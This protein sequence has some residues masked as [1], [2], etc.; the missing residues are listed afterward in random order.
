MQLLQA[1]RNAAGRISAGF[2]DSKLFQ[3][4]G[5]KGEFRERVIQEFLRPFLP[6]CYGL[7]SG[8]VFSETGAS[9]KQID[10]VIYDAAFS[11]VLFRDSQNSLFP[12]E[13]VYGNIEVKSSLTV[14]ELEGAIENI[15]SLKRLQRDDSDMLDLLPF[16]RL[17]VGSGLRY[18]RTKRNPYLGMVVAYSGAAPAAI[19]AALNGQV[20]KRNEVSGLLPDCIFVLDKGYAIVRVADNP[21]AA[22][23][24]ISEKA[25]VCLYKAFDCQGDILPF[26][27]LTLN[28]ALNKII[29]RAPDLDRYW[30]RVCKDILRSHEPGTG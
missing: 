6:I 27:Y 23:V 7:G 16:R 17:V 12:C 15:A 10:V 13:S 19:E 20:R 5:D 28:A 29:L 8:A 11:T 21:K 25:E 4:S 14:G 24:A 9:S 3:H 18:D 22:P 30:T 2:E 26:F 1:L